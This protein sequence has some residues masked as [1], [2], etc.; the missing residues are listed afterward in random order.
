MFTSLFCHHSF[1]VS[2][3][4]KLVELRD[5]ITLKCNL[6]IFRSLETLEVK[7]HIS[8]TFQEKLGYVEELIENLVL[9]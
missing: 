2:G 8:R 9:L 1:Q 6:A 7:C 5:N 3:G 4:R